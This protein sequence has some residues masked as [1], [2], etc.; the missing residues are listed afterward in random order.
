MDRINRYKAAREAAHKYEQALPARQRKELGQYFTGL[1]LGKL[2]AHLGLVADTKTVLDPMAGHGNLLDAAWQAASE[3]NITLDRLDGIEIE[4]ATAEM[5]RLRFSELLDNL[6]L[7]HQCILTSDAFDAPSVK[8]LPGYSYDLVITNPPYVRYQSRNTNGGKNDLVRKGLADVAALNPA[9]SNSQIW[10]TMIEGYSGL[11]DL[12]VPALLGAASFV[13]P[14]GRLALVMPATWRSRDYA[15]VIRYL[16]LRCFRLEY[17]V[18]DTQP[19]WFSDA[20]VRTHLI[21]AQRLPAEEASIPLE[22]RQEWTVAKWLTVSSSASSVISPVG[23]IFKGKSPESQFARWVQQNE[24]ESKENIEV[25]LFHLE[26]ERNDLI[27]RSRHRRWYQKLEK[28]ANDLPL[29]KLKKT[30]V[31]ISIPESF[32]DI[33]PPGFRSKTLSALEGEGIKVGQGLRTGCNNFFYVTYCCD[34]DARS[35]LVKASSLFDFQ[36][37]VVP[38]GAVRPVLRRQSE[39][40]SFEDGNIPA[41][42]VF[43]LRNWILPED[44]EK[45]SGSAKRYIDCGENPPKIMPEELASFVRL[46]AKSYNSVNKKSQLIPE[47]SAVRTNIRKAKNGDSPPRFWYML[48]NFMPRHKPIVFVPRINSGL[49]W[50]DSNTDPGILVDANFSTFWSPEGSWSGY[51]LKALLDSTW[52]RA[53]MESLGT[54]LGGGALKLE[55]THLRHL[56]IPHF[57]KDAKRRLE[58]QGKNLG[59]NT[60]DV[61]SDIDQIVMDAIFSSQSSTIDVSRFLESINNRAQNLSTNRQRVA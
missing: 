37:I 8:K 55:A 19:G 22:K 44:I 9:N 43:S 6:D 48:P 41:G 33:L 12:S 21:V 4:E 18:A 16:L 15:D 61:R 57:S 54:P 1:P 29:F 58:N 51:A 23:S 39:I 35:I 3:R 47:L 42:R 40:A 28:P 26:E 30:R 38:R 49:P 24:M 27:N 7:P 2:L 50:A 56:P 13:R 53:L 10:P 20:L 46:A 52:C 60:Q 11:A 32:R 5:C 31:H 59:R 25:N 36:H 34:I 45:T 14:G 17:V